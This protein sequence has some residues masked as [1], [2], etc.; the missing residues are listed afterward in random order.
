MYDLS[1][2]QVGD[3]PL[4]TDYFQASAQQPM[5]PVDIFDNQIEQRL[6]A[7][8]PLRRETILR[9]TTTKEVEIKEKKSEARGN[10]HNT[11]QDNQS[12]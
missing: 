5:L 2:F 3:Q 8:N 1:H 10:R 7:S 6:K 12:L 9:S 4:D 11:S